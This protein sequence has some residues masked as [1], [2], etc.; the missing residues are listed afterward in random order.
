MIFPPFQP[1]FSSSDPWGFRI[2]TIYPT[3]FTASGGLGM[4]FSRE[5]SLDWILF[6]A[7]LAF[8]RMGMAFSRISSASAFFI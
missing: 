6:K 7:D 1:S 4:A 8:S 5:S 2:N 3:Y